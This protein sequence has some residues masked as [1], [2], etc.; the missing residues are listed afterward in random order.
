MFYKITFLA[1]THDGGW[2]KFTSKLIRAGSNINKVFFKN[3]IS[4]AKFQI[5]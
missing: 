3:F 5:V 1:L 4:L 2:Q